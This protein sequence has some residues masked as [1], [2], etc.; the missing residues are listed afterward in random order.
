MI[1]IRMTVTA[2]S[3]RIYTIEKVNTTFYCFQYICRS[4]NSH[5]I[6]R[7]IFGQ[8]RYCFFNNI[9]HFC[10]TFTYGKSSKCITVKI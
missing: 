10:M 9:I 2:V 7:F 4:S 1:C 6:C 3:C 8:I 5:Q